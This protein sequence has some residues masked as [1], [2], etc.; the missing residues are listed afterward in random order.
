MGELQLFMLRSEGRKLYRA[1]LRA[2]RTAP[3][4]SR[5]EIL[6]QLRSEFK[7]KIGQSDLYAIKYNLSDGRVQLRML[8]EMLAMQR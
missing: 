6:T 3:S 2:I 8:T 5:L 7:R 4:V 1:F